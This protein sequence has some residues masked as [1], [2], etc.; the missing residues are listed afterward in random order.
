[1]ERLILPASKETFQV[2]VTGEVELTV[3]EITCQRLF[4]HELSIFFEQIKQDLDR[5]TFIDLPGGIV[6]I[7]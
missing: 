3:T 2:E 7:L 5:E 6:L 4:L 1:M